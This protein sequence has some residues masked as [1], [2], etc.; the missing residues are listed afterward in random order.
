MRSYLKVKVMSLVAEAKIIRAQEIK[1]KKSADRARQRAKDPKFAESNLF[2]LKT[3]RVTSVRH[4]ARHTHL[5]YGF[6]LGN[7]Y[8]IMEQK[9]QIEPNW[10]KIE[11]MIATYG[12]VT[13]EVDH[14]DGG[15]TTIIDNRDAMQRFSQWRGTA[16]ARFPK[17][18]TPNVP[19]QQ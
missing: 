8:E 3:H 17:E 1:W 15:K 5:A 11:K 19:A 16:A 13:T 14:P 18:T 4:E 9:A 2:G 10:D 12:I 7:A 6:L